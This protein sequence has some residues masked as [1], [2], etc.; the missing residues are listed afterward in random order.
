MSPGGR[1][2]HR[3]PLHIQVHFVGK[4]HAGPLAP[5]LADY[6]ARIARVADLRLVDHR[7]CPTAEAEARLLDASLGA[8]PFVALDERGKAITSDG[9]VGMLQES[10]GLADRTRR[11]VIGGAQGLHPELR[12][13][14]ARVHSLSSVTLSHDLAR[15]LLLEQCY[16]ALATLTGSRYAK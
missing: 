15:L 4:P 10:L 7:S 3:L 1:A 2:P 11:F 12:A 6:A 16:R 13:R 8:A 5:A 14:A 9:I